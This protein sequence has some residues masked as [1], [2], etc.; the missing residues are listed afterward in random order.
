MTIRV[1]MLQAARAAPKTLGES[2]G[3]VQEFL[4]R[5]QNADGG[6]RDRAGKSDIYYTVFGIDG[7]LALGGEPQIGRLADYLR[8]FGNG[9]GLG[10]VHLCCLARCW[11]AISECG[12]PPP[13]GSIKCDLLSRIEGFRSPDGGYHPEAGKGAGTAYGDFL[14]LSAYQDLQHAIPNPRGLVQGLESLATEDA[15]W[16]NDRSV[17]VGSTAA[18]AAAVLVL[19]HLENPVNPAVGTWLM[20]RAHPQG[21]FLAMP[22]APIPDLLS[23]ATAIH[24]LAALGMSLDPIRESCLDFIDSLWTNQG[25]F[26]GLWTDEALDCEYTFYALL[27]LGHLSLQEV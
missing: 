6:F 16:A 3:L 26:H 18:T 25:A 20:A 27:A 19:Q 13:A 9:D 14:A 8:S 24:T 11:A 22:N 23:T 5:Q 1:E 10:L 12:E 2:A 17:R 7:L 15:A 21:G 4:R